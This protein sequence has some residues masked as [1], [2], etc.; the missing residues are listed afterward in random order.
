MY[1]SEIMLTV[2]QAAR[3]VRRNPETVRRWIREGKLRS[4]KMGSP[5]LAPDGDRRT[6]AEPRC[7][8]LALARGPL[9]LVVDASLV[10]NACMSEVGFAPLGRERLVA[11]LGFVVGPT[12]L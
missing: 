12:E 9:T 1:W 6:H 11:H 2:R 10:F 8:D 5:R 4:R 7:C 3:R